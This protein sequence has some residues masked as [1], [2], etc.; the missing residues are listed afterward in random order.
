VCWLVFPLLGPL[1]KEGNHIQVDFLSS[2]V[3]S[4]TNKYIKISMNITAFLA[5]LI[6]FKAGFDATALY[7]RLGQMMEL[8]LD[9]PIWWMYLSFPV[10]F[11]ILA[12]FSIEMTIQSILDAQKISNETN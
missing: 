2:L 11:V 7:Y 4:T 3:S 8:E 10:G 5:S 1:L 6:F 12:L 9:I